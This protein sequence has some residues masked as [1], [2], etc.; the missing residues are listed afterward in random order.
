MA[1]EAEED[2]DLAQEAA[3]CQ[4]EQLDTE[5]KAVPHTAAVVAEDTVPDWLE[6][7]ALVS[8]VVDLLVSLVPCRPLRLPIF[9]QSVVVVHAVV[10][11]FTSPDY[12]ASTSTSNQ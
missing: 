12:L 2:K 5:D 3:V 11:L 1:E 9:Q 8:T 6:D 7:T 4:Q 10:G